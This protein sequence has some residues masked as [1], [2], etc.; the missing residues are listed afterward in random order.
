MAEAEGEIARL[1]KLL[2]DASF[3][4]KAPAAVVEKQQEK[5]DAARD[6]VSR[7]KTHRER[8]GG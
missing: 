1:D 7:L 3:R 2:G 5:L 8:L 6:K 4:D